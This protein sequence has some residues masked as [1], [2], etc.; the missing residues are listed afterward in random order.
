MLHR[1]IINAAFAF[2]LSV[3]PVLAQSIQLAP[4]QVMGNSTSA[5]RPGQATNFSAFMSGVVS[6]TGAPF[7][8]KCDG[9]ADDTTKMQAAIDATPA[10]GKLLL[11]SA[12]A[13]LIAGSGAQILTI[14]KPISIYGAG[15]NGASGLIVASTVPNTRDVIAIRPPADTTIRGIN[16][17]GFSITSQSGSVGKNGI[18]VDTTA[19]TT[20]GVAEIFAQHLYIDAAATTG[21][22]AV[23]VNNGIGTNANGGTFNLTI[24][25]SLF[26]SGIKFT[27]A[28]DSLRVI[29]NLIST[30]TGGILVDQVAGA[31]EFY[32]NGNNISAAGGCIIITKAVGPILEGGVCEQAVANTEANNAVVDV[33][34]GAGASVSSPKI[35]NKQIQVATGTASP[36][37]IGTATGTYL[38]GNRIA[39]PSAYAAIQN[40][41]NASGTVIG[42]G[43]SFSGGGAIIN[44][45]DVT[46]STILAPPSNGK[47]LSI[48][49]NTTGGTYGPSA[50]VVAT[51]I[52][53]VPV[54]NGAGTGWS[55]GQAQLAGG[56]SSSVT[57][58]LPIANGGTGTASG[59]VVSVKKQVFTASGTYTPSTGMLY[60]L[61]ECVGS[62][63]GGGSAAGTVG[64]IYSGAGGGA[65]SPSRIVVTA[66]TIG[67]SKT[68]TVGNAGTGGASG[69]NNG[70]A[71]SDVC[72]TSSTCVSGQI[73]AGKGGTGGLFGSVAQVPT[74]GAGG[75]AG[76]GDLTAA[77]SP[78]LPGFYNAA[79]TTIT[80]PSGAG[81][82]SIFGGGA[83]GVNAAAG[84][85]T[86][87]GNAT[88][89][90]GGG[91]G[92]MANGIASN[93]A[94]GDGSKGVVF[95]TE[96]NSQ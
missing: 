41:V 11:S 5:A 50:D 56:G 70:T 74:G 55:W 21:G 66:A 18:H 22:Y 59:A 34:T 14:S 13:C 7:N 16:L 81:A 82:S 65:G 58:I 19:G 69:S 79:N 8:A 25:D 63:A 53:Q 35:I 51:N 73:C 60:A 71:G 36:I 78:G 93:A 2:M 17:Y 83:Q 23:F 10:H 9:I 28:G 88:N 33:G 6:V 94:G 92:G 26:T 30:A 39:T 68:V 38:A 62:G 87:G 48:I 95:I 15:P 3:S 4:G 57:G 72:V 20:T 76:T 90:G 40:T 27:Q 44:D 43:N 86:T 24:R 91:S 31:G 42:N 96:Y 52:N 1:K 80:F 61:I 89:Y 12:G 77:A 84:A 54:V 47:P 46:H 75:V 85:V 37:R 29:N 45:L 64:N 49:G 67:A 32:E